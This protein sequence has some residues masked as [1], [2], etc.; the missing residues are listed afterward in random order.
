MK[1]VRIALGD[2]LEL[3]AE[4]GRIVLEPTQ[5]EYRLEELLVG[6]TKQNMHAPADFG[7]PMGR[8]TW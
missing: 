8:E 5:R 7:A 4:D 3:K 1:E 2:R 6:I